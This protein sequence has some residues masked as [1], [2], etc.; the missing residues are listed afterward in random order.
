MDLGGPPGRQ[1]PGAVHW[2]VR[3]WRQKTQGIIIGV[4]S[5]WRLPFW[6]NL[7][8]PNTLQPSVPRSPKPNNQQG[9]NT[10]LPFNRQAASSP[11]PQTAPPTTAMKPMKLSSTKNWAGTS[12]SHQEASLSPL[13]SFAHQGADTEFFFSIPG[14]PRLSLFLAKLLPSSDLP[15]P[16]G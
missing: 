13:T 10:N 4:R 8:P 15:H 14:L 2:G 11:T 9:G 6:K 5:P 7:A 12:L 3:H 1:E 16:R